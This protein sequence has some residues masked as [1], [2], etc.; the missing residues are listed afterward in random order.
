LPRAAAARAPEIIA[1]DRPVLLRVTDLRAGYGIRPVLHGISFEVR[2]G[3]TVVLLGL[4]GAGKTT[5]AKALC[6]AVRPWSGSVEFDG[7]AAEHW[8]VQQAVAAGVVMSPEGRHVFPDL[9]VEKNLEVGAWSQRRDSSWLGQQLE[10]VFEYF[11]RLQERR[12][13]NAGSLSGGEQQMLAIARALMA[14]PRMLIIDEA[15]LGLAPVLVE[16]VFEIV[17]RINA[18][19]VTVFLVEQHVGALQVADLALVMEQGTIAAEFRGDELKDSSRVRK[20]FLG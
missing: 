18:D 3:E 8:S 2:A 12:G 20:V 11:P 14:R 19:G 16:T 5:T 7:K 4:N 9:T 13:Q 15:S 17:R 10:R 6:G 1:D